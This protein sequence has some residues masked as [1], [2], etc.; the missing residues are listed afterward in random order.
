MSIRHLLT[1][2]TW[3]GGVLVFA[4]LGIFVFADFGVNADLLLHEVEY[5]ARGRDHQVHLLVDP[6]NV[7]LQ[8]RPAWREGNILFEP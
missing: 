7:V 3:D 8:V 1:F 4:N 5:P 6:H 2:A